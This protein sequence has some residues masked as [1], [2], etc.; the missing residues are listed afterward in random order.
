LFLSGLA[1]VETIL[2]KLDSIR[3]ANDISN[4]RAALAAGFRSAHQSAGFQD[5]LIERGDCIL[6]S[7]F[8]W[9]PGFV[10]LSFVHLK[11]NF[12]HELE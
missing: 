10:R 5:Q 7:S 8:E 9:F 6:R 2:A 1:G 11:R 4:G 3:A 12:L